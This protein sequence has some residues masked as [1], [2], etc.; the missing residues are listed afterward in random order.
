[1]NNIVFRFLTGT[2]MLLFI[3]CVAKSETVVEIGPNFV[4]G[5]H[6]ESVTLLLQKRWQGKYAIGLGYITPQ[7]IDNREY[8]VECE[9][10]ISQQL[11]IG[12]ERRFSWRKWSFGIGLYYVDGMNRVSSSHLNARSSLEFAV[13]QRF[14]IKL[15]H[16]SNGG[17]GSTITVC[18]TGG[19]CVTDKFNLGMNTLA[20]VWQF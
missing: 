13:T 11:I 5:H 7:C 14:S 6:S 15:S 4:L 1:M 8:Q 10:D 18:N 2:I 16:L 20:L 19:W 9:W 12:A 17:T 3:C